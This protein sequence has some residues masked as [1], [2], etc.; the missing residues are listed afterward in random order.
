[1]GQ[2]TITTLLLVSGLVDNR[3]RERMVAAIGAV[4]GVQD[5]Q[6]SL[7]RS[8]ACVVH[9]AACPTERLIRAIEHAGFKATVR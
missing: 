6:V 9:Q 5:V 2:P 4:P 1:M 7:F 8:S 3:A